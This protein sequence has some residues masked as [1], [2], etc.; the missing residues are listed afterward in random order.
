M[1]F[2]SFIPYTLRDISLS[3]HDRTGQD[4]ISKFNKF[5]TSGKI[6]GFTVMFEKQTWHQIGMFFYTDFMKIWPKIRKKS[7]YFEVCF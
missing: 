5:Q 3:L 6:M 4:R 1:I 7:L 2:H